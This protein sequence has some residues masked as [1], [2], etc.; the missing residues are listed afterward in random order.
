M[1][2][3]FNL[4]RMTTATT[5]TGTITLGSAVAGYLTFAQAGVANGDLVA[6]AIKDGNNSEHGI[7]VYTSSGTTLTR[8]VTKSTNSNALISLSG[9]AEVAIS[10]RAEDLTTVFPG[11]LFGLTLSTAGASSS[12]GIAAGRCSDSTAIE[13]MVLASAYTKTTGAWAVGSGNGALDVGT[14][15]ASKG[16]HGYLIKRIDTGVVDAA[17]SL[18]P[19]TASSVTI[20]NASPGVITWPAN[21]LQ[22]NAPVMLSTTGAL[23]TGLTAGVQ[24]F[25]KTVLSVDTFTVSATQGGAVINTSSAGSGVHTT[26]SAPILPTNYTLSRR[27]GGMLTN[28][29]S[30]WEPFF[31][32]G[33]RFIKAVPTGLTV[34]PIGTTAATIQTMPGLPTGIPL[35]ADLSGSYGSLV[36][37]NVMYLSSLLQSDV[38][39]SGTAITAQGS[40]AANNIVSYRV[41]ILLDAASRLRA[42]VGATADLIIFNVNGWTDRRGRDA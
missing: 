26:R 29:S 15:E 25:V 18:A 30:Q 27:L 9:T 32:I 19:D 20:S 34:N 4:A 38:I 8:N 16:Y 7:G 22:A 36:A 3:L 14:I 35:E 28:G 11:A 13:T 6:Y 17:V 12:F 24:Y 41:N 33:D 2:K 21:G 1:A 42:R 23:P 37:T 10:P 31:Q 39:P 40:T 5:L